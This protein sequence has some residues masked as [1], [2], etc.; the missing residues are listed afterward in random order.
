MLCRGPRSSTKACGRSL[1]LT[2]LGYCTA[3]QQLKCG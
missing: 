3:F 2:L 1:L